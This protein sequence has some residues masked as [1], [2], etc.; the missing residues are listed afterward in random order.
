ML[1]PHSAMN[2]VVKID[3]VKTKSSSYAV[4]IGMGGVKEA[5]LKQNP[6]ATDGSFAKGSYVKNIHAIFGMHAQLKTHVLLSIP[7][8][9][10]D[11]LDLR[12]ENKF[13][14]GTINRRSQRLLRQA[15]RCHR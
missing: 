10:H 6:D 12:W 14:E 1:G 8:E 5:E 4:T 9:Y 2:G 13:F 3:G 11:D 15:L 7:E